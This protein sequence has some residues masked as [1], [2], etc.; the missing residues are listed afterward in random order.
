MKKIH[1]HPKILESLGFSDQEMRVFG[2]LLVQQM[3]KKPSLIGRLA[4]VPRSTTVRI[5]LKFEKR[6]L[7]IRGFGAFGSK[8]I[9]WRY[10]KGLERL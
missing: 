1:I 9:L 6:G 3:G 10:K 5:L 8:C 4:G 2:V 7:V